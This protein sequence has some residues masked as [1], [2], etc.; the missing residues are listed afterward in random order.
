VV[1]QEIAQNDIGIN[2][3]HVFH[4]LP[5]AMRLALGPSNPGWHNA[6]SNRV[7]SSCPVALAGRVL[8]QAV[9]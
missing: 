6:S 7:N 9:R 3:A 2:D 5:L 1:I 8:E 4:S